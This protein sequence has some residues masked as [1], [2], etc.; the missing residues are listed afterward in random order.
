MDRS[1][2]SQRAAAGP[3]EPRK[4]GRPPINRDPVLPPYAIEL[5]LLRERLGLSQNAIAEQIGKSGAWWGERE[6]GERSLDIVD[7]EKIHSRWRLRLFGGPVLA[8]VPRRLLIGCEAKSFD[9]AEP[10]EMFVP[11]KRAREV[12]DVFAAEI[13]DDSADLAFPPE[14]VLFL[15]PVEGGELA[16]G[17]HIIVRFLDRPRQLAGAMTRWVLYGRLDRNVAGDLLL[18]TY[19]KSDRVGESLVI[20]RGAGRL[21]ELPERLQQAI[22]KEAVVSYRPRGS[23]EAEIVGLVRGALE[24]F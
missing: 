10:W 8:A 20:Q 19:S 11:P 6:R 2:K 15:E 18:T 4:R 7:G 23:D 24:P 5:R 22:P 1:G 17:A 9:L 12:L 14:T 13:V 16:L 3:F 21:R